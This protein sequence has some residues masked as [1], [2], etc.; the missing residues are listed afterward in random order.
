MNRR[1]FLKLAGVAGLTVASP[2]PWLR[3]VKADG[4]APY[5][6]PLF[7]FVHAGGG[8]D[9]TSFCDPKGR[10]NE[11]EEKPVN[12]YFTDEIGEVGN[13]KHAPIEGHKE[14]FERHR[15]YTTVI[16]GIDT[17]TNGHDSGT[18][19]I[20]SGNLAEG[21][22]SLG[23][24][25]AAVH[26]PDKAMAYITNGGYDLTHGVVAR[27]RV[28]DIGALSRLAYPND[29]DPNNDSSDDRYHTE[30]TMRRIQEAQRSRLEERMEHSHLPHEHAS[31]STLHV[32]R[33]SNN[34]LKRLTE[35]LPDI[36]GSQ[37]KRQ[38]QVAIAAYRAGLCVAA[39]LSM[40][41]FDTHGNHDASHFPRLQTLLGGVNDIWDEAERAGIADRLVVV[42][43]SDFG[44]TPY[45]N[46]NNGKDHWSVTSMVIMGAGVP[47]NRVI[48]GTTERYTLRTV[49]PSSL[50]LLDEDSGERITPAHIHGALRKLADIDTIEKVQRFPLRIEEMP[51]LG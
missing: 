5:A 22:P 35:Y 50:D 46:S 48:G 7:L 10:A 31:M 36:D 29:I 6:G 28:G 8:W 18:R 42:V 1:D 12:M 32:A 33:G 14:F 41:G 40:G 15:D 2:F 47:G 9:P 37:L 25:I 30:A 3:D 16:N 39:N 17:A 45:Y 11:E 34:E 38:A 13:F 24:L 26:A 44:R 23:A 51:L 43:G 27:T 4:D 21:H 49:D 19:H 20:W